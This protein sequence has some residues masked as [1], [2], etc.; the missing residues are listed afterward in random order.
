MIFRPDGII[1]DSGLNG[2]NNNY[3]SDGVKKSQIIEFIQK[4]KKKNTQTYIW[5]KFNKKKIL[6]T[7]KL[8]QCLV[9]KMYMYNY[10]YLP[11]PPLGQDMTQG[12]F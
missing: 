2:P 6:K 9:K 12:Q 1:P 11:T 10:S 7:L 3:T 4:K 8:L 5:K